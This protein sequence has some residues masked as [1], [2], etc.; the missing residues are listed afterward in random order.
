M[1]IDTG[2]IKKDGLVSTEQFALFPGEYCV[3]L[4][5]QHVTEEHFPRI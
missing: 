5:A 1:I 3:S 4:L 2:G